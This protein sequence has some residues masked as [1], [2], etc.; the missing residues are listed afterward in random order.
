[1]ADG[2]NHRI[3]KF[4]DNGT[5][6][7]KWGGWPGGSDD[8][9]F[10]HPHGLVVDNSSYV[11]VADTDN[12][13]IQKFTSSGTFVTKWGGWPHSGDGNFDHP[14]GIA[15]D[16][17]GYVYVADT[18][19]DRVQKFTDN[20]TFV[21]KWGTYGE[22]N[23]Q[24]DGPCGIAVNS[25]PQRIYVA[26]G[27]NNRVEGFCRNWTIRL[28]Q[29]DE[30]T[31]NLDDI[32]DNKTSRSRYLYDDYGNVITKYLDGDTS[33]NDDDATI[34]RVFYPNTTANILSKPA[35]ER[36]YATITGDVGGSN[37]KTETLYYY[38]GNNTSY[39][40]PP[41]KGNLTRLEQKKDA[42]SSV[43]SNFT[44]DSYGNMLTSQD[45]NG[46]TTSWTYETTHHTYPQTKTYP[47]TGLSENYTWDAGAG[48]LLGQTMSTARP[49]PINTIPSSV[50]LK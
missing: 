1:V 26:D 27:G 37:L 2:D 39:T 24:W 5:F 28:N 19:N 25:Q 34:H 7:T 23:G 31:L 33:T 4:T 43:S 21:T 46:N 35:R 48:N 8:G 30:V 15:V 16:N 42:S 11:Y 20:G 22:G 14:L 10:D 18:D 47:V 17:S 45:P 50:W 41:D 13:R 29:V 49:R 38:D 12:N 6:V 44:Y 36:V 9:K 40:T 3:Q 32:T